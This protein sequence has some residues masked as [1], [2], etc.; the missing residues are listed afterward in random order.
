MVLSRIDSSISYEEFKNINDDDKDLE[1][2]IYQMQ[3]LDVDIILT[4]GNI[5]YTYI[6]KNILF[7]PIYLVYDSKVIHKIGVFEFIASNLPEL[8]DED[9]ELNLEKLEKPLLFKFVNKEYLEKYKTKLEES[10]DEDTDEDTDEDEVEIE[11]EDEEEE[12]K[13]KEEDGE[14]EDEDGEKEDED[15]KKEDED[16]EKEDD[17]YMSKSLVQIQEKLK[18]DDVITSET[19]IIRQLYEEDDD[20]IIDKSIETSKDAEKIKKHYKDGTNWVQ[21]YFKNNNYNLIDNEGG[22]D[23]LFAVIRDAYNSIGKS[24]TVPQLRKILARE[25]NT[26][27]FENYKEIYD[28]IMMTYNENDKEMKHIVKENKKLKSEYQ[29]EGNVQK[30]KVLVDKSKQL[31]KKFEKLKAEQEFSKTLL[32]EY[33]FMHN[34]NNLEDFKNIIKTCKFWGETWAISTL[35]RVLNMKLIIFSQEAYHSG[36]YKNIIQ[37]GQLNDAILEER[38]EF[39]P[40]YYIMTEYLGW[41]YKTITYKDKKLLTFEE[42]PFDVKNLIVD[43]CLERGEGPFGIIPKFRKIKEK[44][45]EQEGISMGITEEEELALESKEKSDKTKELYDDTIIFQFYDKSAHFKP[46]KGAG[47]KIDEKK[48]KDFGALANIKNW[49]RMLSNYYPSEFKF[50]GKKWFSVAH[51]L[52]GSKYKKYNPEIYNLFSLDSESEISKNIS[53]VKTLE[54]KRNYNGKEIIPKDVKIDEDYSENILENIDDILLAKFNQNDDMKKALKETQNAKL[55]LYNV[56]KPPVT[57]YKL[58]EIRKKLS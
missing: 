41:H 46:G 29:K 38:G 39:K 8:M 55:I 26:K 32:N 37:C 30:Q 21:K 47:E 19:A 31:V 13:K 50:D 18:D 17:T 4:I 16:G 22:G 12:E 15:G 51:Y 10:E 9:D 11:E 35:E 49:R 7:V 43:K 33:K 58:M 53:A 14:K 34:I 45:I 28:Q 56:R 23:C 36:D 1:A 40:K 27:I 2:S 6:G 44:V 5:K 52:E 48:L 24:I 57:Q 20:E 3:L 42:I 54:N 25:A